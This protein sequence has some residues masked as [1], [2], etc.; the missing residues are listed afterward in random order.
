MPKIS[1][2]KRKARCQR[3]LDAANRC[4]AREGFH[5]TSME[6]I[7]RESGVSPG[8]IYC[9]FRGKR[10][11]V[12]AIADQRHR[13]ESA[14][15]AKLLTPGSLSDQL[16]GLAQ[17]FFGMLQDPREKERRK[18]TIQI[19]AE[20]L[21]DRELRKIVARGLRQRHALTAALRTAQRRGQL[22]RSVLPDALSRV[23]MAILQGFI[24]Q[25]AWEPDL[26]VTRFV[27]TATLLI[28]SALDHTVVSSRGHDK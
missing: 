13:Q 15:L 4:F 24:L 1:A 6:D 10:E 3:I 16:R 8:A 20:S 14:L 25:Q 28:N 5:R 27:D 9:Y 26:N 19:W 22:K 21:R 12:S 18:V 2:E 11:I 7:V 23:M 17:D